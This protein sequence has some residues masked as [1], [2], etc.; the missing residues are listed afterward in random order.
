MY[1]NQGFGDPVDGKHYKYHF[2]YL[3]LNGEP[4]TINLVR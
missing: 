2:E 3:H 4:I 1:R